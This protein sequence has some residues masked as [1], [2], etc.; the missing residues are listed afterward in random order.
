[1]NPIN[2]RKLMRGGMSVLASALL[3]KTNRALGGP[4]LIRYEASSAEGQQMLAKYSKA[5]ALMKLKPKGNPCSWTFWWYTHGVWT[6]DAFESQKL[7]EVAALP[8]AQQPLASAAWDTCQNHFGQTSEDMFLPWH[9]MYVYYFERVLRQT[10]GDPSFTLPYWNYNA[11]GT[12]ALPKQFISPG[13]TQNSLWSASRYPNSNSGNPLTGLDLNA[14]QQPSYSGFSSTLDF[15]LHGNV[16]VQVGNP[17]GMGALPWAANDPVFWMHHCNIDRLWASWNSSG[18]VNPTTVTWLNQTFTFADENCNQVTPRVGDFSATDSLGYQYDH[19][20]GK[21]IVRRI[22]WPL[23]IRV[24]HVVL[25]GPGP[26]ELAKAQV[27]VSLAPRERFESRRSL[28]LRLKELSAGAR[29]YLVLERLMAETPPGVTYQ[30]HLNTP[31]HVAISVGPAVGT[32]NF[33][34]AVMMKSARAMD[35]P[36]ISFDVTDALRSLQRL[37]KLSDRLSVTFVADGEPI[38]G[39]KPLIGAVALV[40]I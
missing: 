23:P 29:L 9:R 30:L 3:V 7:Q 4:P 28:A 16:H 39:S 8:A 32:I 35:P 24:Q 27:R 22:K 17:H 1:M 19:L 15:G 38:D 13:G 25:W 36:S 5:V 21:P 37:T 2:R 18:G 26:I 31:E 10:L 6:N 40:E 20:E 34:A 14:L 12:R 33:F 11:A